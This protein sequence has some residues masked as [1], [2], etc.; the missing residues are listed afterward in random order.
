MRAR[1][2]LFEAF[3]SDRHSRP[4]HDDLDEKLQ[5][6]LPAHGTYLEAGANDGY[7][8]SNTYYLERFKGWSGILVEGIPELSE[9][10]RRTRPRS[11]VHNCALVPPDFP[12]TH[13]TMTYGD[14]RSLIKGSQSEL[15]RR[16]AD[17]GESGY[18]VEAVARTLDQVIG[19][20]AVRTIDF[21][22]LDLEGFEAHALRGLD[23]DRW[24][25]TWLL[26]EVE[27][28]ERRGAVEAVLA[29]RYEAAEA[30]TAGD[31]LYRRRD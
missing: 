26:V 24:G 10:C 30:L 21:M 2:Q 15:E 3:G 29:D 17:A 5:R 13:V 4:G 19:D 1:R 31:V 25:P 6:Y 23:F 12:D 27:G 20:T 14:L 11:Q 22:S 28:E 16:A 18:E 7:T 8:W 9:E